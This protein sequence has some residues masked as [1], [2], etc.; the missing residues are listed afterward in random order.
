MDEVEVSV[1]FKLPRDWPASKVLGNVL[2][3]KNEK[4]KKE[5]RKKD[6]SIVPIIYNNHFEYSVG[7]H[8]A[9]AKCGSTLSAVVVFL[10]L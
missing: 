8:D 1:K 10:Q 7:R 4:T 5:K 6:F 9:C 3:N 2:T